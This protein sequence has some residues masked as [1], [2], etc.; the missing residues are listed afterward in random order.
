MKKKCSN[1]NGDFDCDNLPTCWC[2]DISKLPKNKIDDRC[3]CMCKECL[4]ENIKKNYLD[5]GII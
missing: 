2:M 5:T 1:C 4:L 3:D